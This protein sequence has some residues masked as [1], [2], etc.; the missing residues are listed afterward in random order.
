MSGFELGVDA[1]S[2]KAFLALFD[3]LLDRFRAQG[4]RCDTA[5]F[6]AMLARQYEAIAFRMRP[7]TRDSMLRVYWHAIA[8][9]PELLA[10][11]WWTRILSVFLFGT[12]GRAWLARW[13]RRNVLAARV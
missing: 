9:H 2:A 12:A 11:L 10:S 5:D 13:K 3:D 4:H 8:S 7:A 1:G 6:R